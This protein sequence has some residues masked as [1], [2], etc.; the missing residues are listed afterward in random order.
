IFLKLCLRAVQPAIV[1][2]LGTQ[3]A[4]ADLIPSRDGNQPLPQP[5]AMRR[6]QPSYRELAAAYIE[7]QVFHV[8][9][10]LLVC[11]RAR[12][13]GLADLIAVKDSLQVTPVAG[14]GARALERL[15]RAADWVLIGE[16]ARGEGKCEDVLEA[17]R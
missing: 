1:V 7:Q 5:S 10:Y 8:V 15:R 2:V 17:A 16:P 4:Q 11:E 3:T 9:L 14:G 13:G 6:K 12:Q